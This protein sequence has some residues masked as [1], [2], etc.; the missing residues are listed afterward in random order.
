MANSLLKREKNPYNRSHNHEI[1][2]I[3]SHDND[4]IHLICFCYKN[5]CCFKQIFTV[6]ASVRCLESIARDETPIYQNNK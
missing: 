5:V 6:L 4:I 2:S 1:T 3:F